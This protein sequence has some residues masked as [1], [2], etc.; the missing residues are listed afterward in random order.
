MMRVLVAL[1]IACAG[2]IAPA[3]AAAR[4]F[5]SHDYQRSS[6][7]ITLAAASPIVDAYFASKALLVAHESGLDVREA[8]SRWI[9]WMLGKQLPDGRF[10]RYTLH[11]ASDVER[12]GEI[13]GY[14]PADADDA[15]LAVWIE[16]LSKVGS[17]QGPSLAALPPAWVRSLELATDAL[18]RLLDAESGVYHISSQQPVA[19]LMDNVE[20][21]SAWR[22]AALFYASMGEGGRA[23]AAQRRA[24]ALAANI[25]RTFWQRNERRYSVSTQPRARLEFYP[26]GVA[27]FYPLL[28]DLPNRRSFENTDFLAWLRA[29]AADWRAAARHDFPWGLVAVAAQRAGASDVAACWLRDIDAARARYR[30]NVLEEAAYQGLRHE[31]GEGLAGGRCAL[32]SESVDEGNRGN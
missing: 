10:Q 13:A 30:W 18:D 12:L 1:A 11:Q 24:T 23:L 28:G 15:L 27:Q 29:H 5:A 14:A 19:L 8:A 4:S 31:L 2:A 21:Y 20:V 3:C 25:D 9:E 26:D 7:A 17:V 32:A 6:G 16:L 22:H